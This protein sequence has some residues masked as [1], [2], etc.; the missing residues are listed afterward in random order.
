M[1]NIV[2]TTGRLLIECKQCSGGGVIEVEVTI[3]TG[4][5]V[6]EAAMSIECPACEGNGQFEVEMEFT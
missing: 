4:T 1:S 3:H 5:N 2:A 6:Q